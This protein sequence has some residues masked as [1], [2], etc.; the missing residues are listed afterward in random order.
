MAGD[1]LE[2]L[3]AI[4]IKDGRC[5]R[6]VQGDFDRVTTFSDDPVAVARRWASLGAKWLH[7]VDLDGAR[8][9][10]PSPEVA[11]IVRDIFQAVALPIQFG[12]GVR[13][14]SAIEQ[15]LNNGAARVVVGTAV[16]VDAGLAQRIF[17][18]WGDRVAVAV[19]ARDG[20]VQ[21][22]GWQEHIGEKATEYMAR[23]CNLGARRF[24]F[25]DTARDGM[26]QGINQEAL[27]QALAAVPGAPVIASGGVASIEDIEA[28]V[29]LRATGLRN[30]E[31]VIVG[32]ALYTGGIDLQQA[33]AR[34]S[35]PGD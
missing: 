16:A 2:I 27:A 22:S 17:T 26:L 12:G 20:L 21:I 34:A 7:I 10:R 28:L 1:A 18:A 11:G 25:T 14:E 30:I 5:V 4:D 35:A 33:L 23:M 6:L 3:P 19:D 29:R 9:G 13:S 24:V 8:L 15:I 31:G 32:K